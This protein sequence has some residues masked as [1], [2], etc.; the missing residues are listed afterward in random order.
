MGYKPTSAFPH[1]ETIN[2]YNQNGILFRCETLGNSDVSNV[3]LMISNGAYEYYFP[4]NNFCSISP[5]NYSMNINWEYTNQSGLSHAIKLNNSQ[6][7]DSV[8][9]NLN[10]SSGNRYTWQMRLYENT[11][12]VGYVPS[13][14]IGWGIISNVSSVWQKQ[15]EDGYIY[16]DRDNMASFRGA[17]KVKVLK[18]SPHT[19][20]YF[21]NST[22]QNHWS[23]VRPRYIPELYSRYDKNARY[24]L[25][26][27]GHVYEIN[28]YKFCPPSEDFRRM[29]SSD[30]KAHVDAYGTPLYGYAV[31]NTDIDISEGDEYTLYCN[32][33]DTDTY[34][35]ETGATPDIKLYEYFENDG[36]PIKREINNGVINLNYSNLH[37]KGEYTQSNGA[38]V[39]HYRCVLE[40][41]VNETLDKYEIV[42]SSNDIY[43]PAI[44]YIYDRFISSHKYR[45]TIFRHF[46]RYIVLFCILFCIVNIHLGL[47]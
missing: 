11:H 10:I 26:V 36:S 32:Y 17:S 19:N 16:T 18:I 41:C 46:R 28:D 21:A 34:Y 38:S 40:E 31:F 1:G 25:K 5:D 39:S 9:N 15:S 6:R 44:D 8:P 13:S 2:P 14:W 47:L 45:L 35:F 24:Y 43:S 3:R 20:M 23:G 30:G 7:Y 22:S 42:H 37:I 29:D 12:T 27:N 33:I 4:R